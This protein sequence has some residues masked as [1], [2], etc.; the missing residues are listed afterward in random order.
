MKRFWKQFVL[1]AALGLG[2]PAIVVAWAVVTRIPREPEAS[3]EPHLALDQQLLIPVFQRDGS[4][5]TMDMETYLTGVILAEMPTDFELE[6]LKAQ[7]IVARTYALKR[8]EAGSKHEGGGVCTD[9]GCCQGYATSD[10]F[11]KAQ[12]DKV[13]QAVAE[14]DGLVL[15]YGG[16]FID[17]TYFSSSGGSTE[18]AI[19]VWGTDV[20][21]L[22]A[23]DSP[24]EENA[25]HDTD[26]VQFS[27]EEFAGMLEV[28]LTGDPASW[29]GTI[30]HTSGGGVDTIEIGGELY[31]GTRLRSILGLRS[32]KFNI[33]VSGDTITIETHGFGHRVG[34]SQY[35]A[36]AMA[37]SGSSCAEILSHYYPGT[38][39]EKMRQQT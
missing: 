17:A 19:A 5:E 21:Y 23:V 33:S 2:L 36:D 9:P 13:C 25:A 14:T 35:G 37:A 16:S 20:P 39:L 6:A 3:E 29:F 4:L 7:A 15:T 10:E 12:V 27:G 31:Q 18:A 26:Y 24:G 11:Q 28:N 32:T 8:L 1:A 38:S 34:M 30:T 22:Q